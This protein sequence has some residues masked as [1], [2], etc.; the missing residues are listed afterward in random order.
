MAKTSYSEMY[1]RNPVKSAA[2]LAAKRKRISELENGQAPR[3]FE[4]LDE[5]RKIVDRLVRA[6]RDTE[7]CEICG[8]P[9]RDPVSVARGIGPDCWSRMS[10]TDGP[11]LLDELDPGEAF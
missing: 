3:Q 9:L 10:G 1:L 8:H 4:S 2:Q 7:R 5:H 6:F 11:S